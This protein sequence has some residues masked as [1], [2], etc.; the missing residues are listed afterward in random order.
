MVIDYLEICDFLVFITETALRK[1]VRD[2]DCKLLDTQRIAYGYIG[3]KL[4][5]R[6]HIETEL[7]KRGT[8]RNA[9]VVRWMAIL[10][11]YYLYQSIPD[12]D[13]PER[14]RLNFE[15]VVREIDRIASGKA[16]CTLEAV[17]DGE[18]NPRTSFRWHSSPRR[19]HNP[20][21]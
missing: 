1:L 8:A 4:H 19:T 9:A 2:D 6:Y 12:G 7:R 11:V 5:G 21:N 3:E 20:F 17:T 15:D 13:I 18:G 10:T 16:G 14:V